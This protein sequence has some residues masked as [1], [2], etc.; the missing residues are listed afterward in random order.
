ML[1]PSVY[2]GAILFRFLGLKYY[3]YVCK[4]LIDLYYMK[5]LID[6]NFY[7][8]YNNNS[9]TNLNA[10]LLLIINVVYFLPLFQG[11]FSFIPKLQTDKGFLH[12]IITCYFQN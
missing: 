6:K 3:W 1:R 12:F 5:K 4:I 11:I 7:K 10:K 9:L 2:I 8:E